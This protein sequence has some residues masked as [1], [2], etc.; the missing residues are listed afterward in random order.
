MTTDKPDQL[1][2]VDNG[3]GTCTQTMVFKGNEIVAILPVDFN[4]II[5][6]SLMAIGLTPEDMEDLGNPEIDQKLD[7]IM[8]D[9]GLEGSVVI[10]DDAEGV[11]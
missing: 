11:E 5:A 2:V 7:Q 9:A 1:S 8:R 3:D 6:A 10:P 4:H